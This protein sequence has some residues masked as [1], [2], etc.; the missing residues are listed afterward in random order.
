MIKREPN[1]KID[2]ELDIMTNR[3]VKVGLLNYPASNC[4]SGEFIRMRI[5]TTEISFG[6]KLASWWTH[7]CLRRRVKTEEPTR[8]GSKLEAWMGRRTCAS[9]I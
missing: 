2:L 4:Y 9:T 1:Q 8:C 3:M 7:T 6:G 5:F